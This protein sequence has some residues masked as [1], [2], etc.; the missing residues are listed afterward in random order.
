MVML[1]LLATASFQPIT[2]AQPPTG[3]S[4]L[5]QTPSAK[6]TFR[7]REKGQPQKTS[8]GASRD[9]GVCPQDHS[10]SNPYLL[11]VIPAQAQALTI[12][13]HPTLLA[14][15]PE[16]SANQ[17]YFSIINANNGDHLYHRYIPVSD[18]GII[19]VTIPDDTPG[20]EL[21][22][23]YQWSMS[24]ICE[25]S[26][27]P[28]SPLV[29]GSIE[30]IKLDSSLNV[31]LA[32]LSPLE[33]VSVL[34]EQGIWYDAIANLAQIRQQF[35]NNPEIQEAWQSFLNGE[36]LESIVSQPFMTLSPPSNASI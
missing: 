22:Q 35:P 16:T 33:Q 15:V 11:P 2:E 20:L 34:G 24:L 10:H 19:N 27:A 13:E 31:S 32:S 7:P 9:S 30:R 21:H 8:G 25:S 28:D 5:S 6:V 14:Y 18:A 3:K 23:S 17:I 4:R 26:L 1:G 12:S 36:G 29:E